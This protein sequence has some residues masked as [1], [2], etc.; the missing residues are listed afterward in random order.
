MKT[1]EETKQVIE[2]RLEEVLKHLVP[3]QTPAVDYDS[4]VMRLKDG[5]TVL[6]LEL[7]TTRVKT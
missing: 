7:H 1:T 4:S 6:V 2:Y 5:G 3:N